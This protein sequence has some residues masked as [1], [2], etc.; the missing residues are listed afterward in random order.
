MANRAIPLTL[1]LTLRIDFIVYLLKE[2]C[3]SKLIYSEGNAKK[4]LR[5]PDGM[6]L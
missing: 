5:K 1:C 3:V 2:K 4:H 6:K